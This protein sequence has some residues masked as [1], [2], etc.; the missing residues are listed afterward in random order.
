MVVATKRAVGSDYAPYYHSAQPLK[1]NGV[2]TRTKKK[3]SPLPIIVGISL[4]SCAFLMAISFTCLKAVIAHLNWQ[5]SQIE[6][7]NI[8]IQEDNE[9]L[10]LDI[11]RLK[12]LDRIEQ[13]ATVQMGMVKNPG[14]EYMVMPSE[15][16]VQVQVPQKQPVI[17]VDQEAKPGI[18]SQLTALLESKNKVDKG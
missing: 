13:V 4:I 15:D 10:T 5:I 2:E 12:S 1:A 3:T 11:A 16:N 8:V 6:E 14:V 9:K 18:L 7:E 17:P